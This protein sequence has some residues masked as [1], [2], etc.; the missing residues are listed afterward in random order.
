MKSMAVILSYLSAAMRR[1]DARLVGRLLGVFVLLV[2]VYSVVFHVLMAREGQSHSWPTSVYWTLVTMTTLG[3]GDIT[4]ESDLGRVFSVVVL[5]S[6]TAFLLILLPFTF[7]QFVF[8]PWMSQR[9]SSRAPRALPETTRGHLVLT[10]LGP[11]EDALIR[12]ARQAQVPYVLIVT[13]LEDAL[14][15][16][17]EGYAVMVGTLDALETYRA[18]RVENAAL[19]VATRA[20]T[21]NTN[22]SFTVREISSE[23]PV[24]ATAN[25]EASI[26]ILELAGADV[27]L[28]LGEML[29]REMAERS[30]APDGLAHSIGRFAD[31]VIAEARVAS[32]D[33]V[34]KTLAEAK[35]RARLG[36]GIIGV[37][38][39]GDFEIASPSTRL[40]EASV[41]I[42][43]AH[44][45]QLVRYDECYATGT[46]GTEQVIIVGGGRVGRAAGRAFAEANTAY[47][48]IEQQS[49][50][51]RDPDHYVLG[52]AADLSVLESAGIRTVSSVLITT[53]DDDTNVYL[54]IYCRRLRPDVRIVSR[55]N[56]DR[57]VSTLYR[58]GADDVLSYGST[59]AEA[60]WNRFREADTLV[61]AEGLSVFR[62]DVPPWLTGVTIAQSG[63]RRLTGCNVVAVE[64]GDRIDSNPG[65][66]AVLQEGSKLL[67][68]G[69]AASEARFA[70]WA[71]ARPPRRR[72]R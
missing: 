1:R 11:I 57:N 9:A 45:D 22:I 35:L 13:E 26:D 49:D 10:G 38:E 7:I 47:R 71:Q 19:V 32:T 41:L 52:D 16:H 36:V 56:L 64:H 20:D 5:L 33:L 69:D 55:A 59:G 25:K 68:I 42:L 18:V 61:V 51:V 37:W 2:V 58:A 30:L 21:T 44:P 6:G 46:A 62:A 70:E 63:I 54:T 23:V 34:G 66:A 15:L 8:V 43:A 67:L 48:I 12:R 72:R 29:G 31:L 3:F 24:V 28:R 27:V 50:R 65:G 39:H 17:D 53:H 40:G 14:R 60:I 4:F